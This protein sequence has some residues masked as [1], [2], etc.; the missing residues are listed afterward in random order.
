MA[1]T[2]VALAKSVLTSNQ[3]SVTFNSFSSAYTDLIIVYSARGTESQVNT[4]IYVTFNGGTSGYSTTMLYISGAT[5][6]ASSRVSSSAK[7]E[8]YYA[9]NANTATSNT[10]GNGEIYIPNYNG[11]TQKPVSISSVGENNS[12]ATQAMDSV[13]AG[14][15]NLTSAI[16]SITISFFTTGGTS[17]LSGSSF[18]LYGIK[19]S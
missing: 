16:T 15:S 9:I 6:P 3:A 2:Y 4:D 17:I 11:T 8:G 18:Y 13:Y 19:S 1:N 14:L 12:S 10:F 5:T 7:I